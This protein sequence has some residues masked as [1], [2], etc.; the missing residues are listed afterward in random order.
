[1]SSV[2]QAPSPLEQANAKLERIV[3]L[4][5]AMSAEKDI[6]RLVE[7][8]LQGAKDLS[9]ADG[10]SLYLLGRQ[11]RLMFQIVLNDSL[12]FEQG[13][14]SGKPVTMP[15]V[16]LYLP[17][18][19]PNH[20]NVVTHAFHAGATVNVAD[21]YDES[22][23]DF[24]G[25]R[26]FDRQTGYRS[27]SFLTVPLRPRGGE[28]MGAL[29]LINAHDRPRAG[30]DPGDIVAFSP[31]IQRFVEAL[32]A[33]AATALYNRD[34]IEDQKQLFDAMIEFTAGAI[35]A[36]SHYT[37]AHCERVPQLAIMIAQ[38]ASKVDAGPLA[39]FKL[40]GDDQWYEFKVGAWLHDCGKVTTPEFVVDK[41]TKLETIHN[42]IHEVRARFEVLLRDARIQRLE[43]LLAGGDPAE[44]D[45]RLAAETKS[46]EDDF[47]FVAACNSGE[48]A[49]DQPKLERLNRIAERT[50]NRHFDDRLG[51]SW[52]EL[53]RCEDEPPAPLPCPERLL[54]DKPIHRIKRQEHF[55]RRYEGRGFT[56]PVPA[57]LYDHGELH[58]LA[59]TRGTLNEEER[60]KINEHIMQT[61][62]MLE[63]LP[64]PPSMARV[65]YIAGTH[66]ESL[67]GRGYPRQMQAAE[68]DTA[69]RIMA[70]A[71]I[72]EALSATDRPYK[73]TKKLSECVRILHGFKR[74]G[75][76]DADIFDLFL[77]SGLYRRY[78]ERFMTPDQIDEVDAASYL[79]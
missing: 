78:A 7:T 71:D 21:A 5:I 54:A 49:M 72:F 14:T 67:T 42:R 35:D 68:L 23:F 75:H 55:Y 50:W 8:I 61:I 28:V 77:S 2:P 65:P 41:A 10:G 18:G 1:M 26:E 22:G 69:A 63:R 6:N 15:P 64:L 46:L 17:D 20:H 58:N 27:R 48:E 13:G 9:N 36:K 70:I 24:S 43:S 30:G 53:Q 59:I 45:A 79:G 16:E 12:G 39:D 56:L 57:L 33:Q 66:H 60:F 62:V 37:G 34:L 25:T 76:I 52:E 47:A 40:E 38:E 4:G 31:Q 19:A 3:E 51:L 29:Q 32:A 11:K 74:D 44:A 73:K